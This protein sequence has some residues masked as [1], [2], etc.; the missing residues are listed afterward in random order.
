[1][2]K[3]R[4]FRLALLCV[5]I[6]FLIQFFVPPPKIILAEAFRLPSW[7]YLLGTTPLGQS[8]FA[9]VLGGVGQTVSLAVTAL[10]V[11]LVA[12]LLVTALLYLTPKSFR[13]GYAYAVDAWLAIPGI[14]IALSIG[15]FLPQS[16]VS[17]LIA[18]VLSEFAALQKFILQRL[19]NV[20]RND[21]ITMAQAMGAS[22]FHTL[23]THVIPRLV[24]ET[25]YL[26][27]LTLPS[28]VLSLSSLEFLGVQTGSEELSLGMQIALYK[29]YIVLYP[30]L[31]LPP[32]FTLLAILLLLQII[33]ARISENT[34]GV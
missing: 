5:L 2:K 20:S 1:M 25:A 12:A 31:S 27:A 29:D 34:A 30:H 23:R 9:L 4:L 8:V 7:E 6:I 3:N 28:I 10:S 22:R 19:D 15:Y 13:L 11:C 16:F 18:L 32:V 21:F 24:R 26:F 33:S 14:F 17:V